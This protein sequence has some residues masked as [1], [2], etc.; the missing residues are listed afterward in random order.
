MFIGGGIFERAQLDGAFKKIW[1]YTLTLVQGGSR[2]LV[3]AQ[4]CQAYRQQT[5]RMGKIGSQMDR[6]SCP[7]HCFFV[8]SRGY[9]SAGQERVE[10]S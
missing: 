2:F 9:A 4:M 1:L 5:V 3:P 6:F 7:F 10:V 8:P